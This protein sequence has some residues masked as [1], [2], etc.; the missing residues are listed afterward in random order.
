MVITECGHR[1]KRLILGYFTGL[2]AVKDAAQGACHWK[3]SFPSAGSR[4]TSVLVWIL[5]TTLLGLVH[6]KW[7]C[8]PACVFRLTVFTAS[9]RARRWRLT[10]ST[11]S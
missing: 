5:L 4:R 6:G 10:T 11:S 1:T 3:S 8:L 7:S 2:L 9:V